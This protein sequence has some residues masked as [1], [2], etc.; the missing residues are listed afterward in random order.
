MQINGGANYITA[1]NSAEVPLNLPS[2]MYEEANGYKTVFDGDVITGIIKEF[3]DGRVSIDLGN[4]CIVNAG[5]D[6]ALNLIMGSKVSMLVSTLPGNSIELKPL[7]TNMAQ[8]NLA[9]RAIADA[10]VPRD[11]ISMKLVS[12]LLN[13]EMGIDR[14]SVSTMYRQIVSNGDVDPTLIV[15]MNKMGMDITPSNVQSFGA[16]DNFSEKISETLKSLV[17]LIPGE[18]ESLSAG[19]KGDEAVAL[20]KECLN[21]IDNKAFSD[22]LAISGNTQISPDEVAGEAVGA[23]ASEVASE[24]AV[25]DSDDLIALSNT[26]DMSKDAASIRE[27][28][29]DVKSLINNSSVLMSN[30]NK[31]L[32]I[33]ALRAKLEQGICEPKDVAVFF[34]NKNNKNMFCEALNKAFAIKPEEF[35]H[36]KDVTEFYSD[37]CDKVKHLSSRLLSAVSGNENLTAHVENFTRNIDFVDQLNKFVP[38]IQLPIKMGNESRT[39]DLCVYA[40]KKNLSEPGEAVTALLRLDMQYLGYTEVR[41]ALEQTKV[42]TNFRLENE[43]ALELVESHLDELSERMAARGYD[44]KFTAALN[45]NNTLLSDVIMGRDSDKTADDLSDRSEIY[46]FDVRA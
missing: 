43:A 35:S 9:G 3:G 19:D 28:S 45:D 18:I 42:T 41:V 13:E 14:E 30:E 44:A 16:M 8:E 17:D 11:D 25:T 5:C 1:G 31:S 46:R 29:K 34:E 4:N 20:F 23:A 21:I 7:F 33:G 10:G 40:N 2:A 12:S 15:R 24:F 37:L 6:A 22:D 38:Y 39:G 36:K 32:D 27:L 26:S